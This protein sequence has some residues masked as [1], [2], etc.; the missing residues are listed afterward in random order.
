MT[1]LGVPR[2]DDFLGEVS[3]ELG[4]ANATTLK[5]TTRPLT[6]HVM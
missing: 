2:N 6:P 5:S 4:G 3:I 1:Y